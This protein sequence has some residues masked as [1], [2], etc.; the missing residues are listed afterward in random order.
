VLLEKDGGDM[1][2]RSSGK[3]SITQSKG[4]KE[5]PTYNQ[6]EKG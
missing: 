6:K 1:L 5:Y 3:G 2:D 4:D